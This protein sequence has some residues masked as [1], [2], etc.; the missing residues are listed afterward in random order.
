MPTWSTEFGGSLEAHEIDQITEY[1]LNWG[2]ELCAEDIVIEAV[3][4]PESWEDLPAGDADAGVDA[5]L[6]QGC[7]GCHGLPDSPAEN[8]LGVG[9]HLGNIANVGADRVPG[10]SAEQYIY[11]SILDPNA[12]IVEECPLGPCV[13]PSQM[14]MDYPDVLTEQGMADLIAYYMTLTAEN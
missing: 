8:H 6:A 3:E 2:E 1:V 13:E 14:R 9:P 10:M 4:W 7:T 12:F 5:Y 11:E